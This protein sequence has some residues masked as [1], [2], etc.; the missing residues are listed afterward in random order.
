M[1]L[2]RFDGL[3]SNWGSVGF[4][5]NVLRRSMSSNLGVLRFSAWGQGRADY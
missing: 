2:A 3:S 4:C 5:R 1:V